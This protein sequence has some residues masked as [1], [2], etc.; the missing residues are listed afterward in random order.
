MEG[1]IQ[2]IKFVYLGYYY[3][4]KH[5]S[6]QFITYTSKNLLKDYRADMETLLNGFVLCDTNR[7]VQANPGKDFEKKI[8]INANTVLHYKKDIDEAVP[9]Q[10]AE[11]MTKNGYISPKLTTEIYLDI[12]NNT[13]KLKFVKDESV[14]NYKEVVFSFNVL[15]LKLNSNLKL[16]KE[17]VIEFTSEDLND[18]FALPHGSDI[19]NETVKEIFKLKIYHIDD[20]HTIEYNETMPL[21]ELKKIGDA[22]KRLKYD[23][24]QRKMDMI[25]LNNGSDY[26]LK[27]FVLKEYWNS[28]SETERCKRIIKY[29]KDCGIRKKINLNFIDHQTYEE[30]KI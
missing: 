7:E 6:I 20:F 27:F 24:P 8:T 1:T 26:T 23:F 19:V 15:E 5:G 21:S 18:S 14:L 2:G 11:F 17:I 3:S 22:V 9:K 12:E 13:Y 10:I 30:T 29:F 25:F 28:P 16:D 4:D